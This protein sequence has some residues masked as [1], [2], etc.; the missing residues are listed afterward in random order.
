MNTNT[1]PDAQEAEK[2]AMFLALMNKIGTAF[3]EE[4]SDARLAVY[5]ERLKRYNAKKLERALTDALDSEFRFPSIAAIRQWIE[6]LE[7]PKNPRM[8]YPNLA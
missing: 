3:R 1:G 5:W 7:D 4:V 6:P 2:E 8:T